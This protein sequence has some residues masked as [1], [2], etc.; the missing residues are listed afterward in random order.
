MTRGQYIAALRK[1]V[2]SQAGGYFRNPRA[3]GT[4]QICATPLETGVYCRTCIKYRDIVGG[5]DAFGIMTYSGRDDPIRQSGIVMKNYKSRTFV[6]AQSKRVVRLVLALALRGHRDCLRS[7]IGV[8]PTAWATI[9]TLPHKQGAHP[10]NVI[11]RDLAKDNAKEIVLAGAAKTDD[12]RSVNAS[13]FTVQTAI[14]PSTHVLLIDD[15][16]TSGGH[17]LSA[18]LAIRSAGAAQV[19]ALILSRYLD[20]RW[21]ETPQGWIRDNLTRPDFDPT[22][23]PWTR[24]ACP[25]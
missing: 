5:P 3:S 20:A 9:P 12:A 10:L 19:S 1:E 15:T 7:L 22:I 16:W 21:S 14:P 8:G 6:D 17:V 4:C 23:C 11:V 24:G 18:A 25:A 13:H 2:V